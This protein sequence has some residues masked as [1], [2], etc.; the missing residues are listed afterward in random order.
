MQAELTAL[1]VI[2]ESKNK[3][4]PR[5]KIRLETQEICGG[6]MCT[7]NVA[8]RRINRTTFNL[9]LDRISFY[10]PVSVLSSLSNI[11]EKFI[12]ES[13]TPFVDKFLSEF[14]SAYR[15]AYSTNHDILR[16]IE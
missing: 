8:M 15:K 13:I 11:Y 2:L 9:I 10:R 12:Q 6:L 5:A 4:K 3:R 16:L 7:E 14:I 1:V